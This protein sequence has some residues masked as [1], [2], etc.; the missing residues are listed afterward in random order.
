MKQNVKYAVLDAMFAMY[1][2]V[3]LRI[4]KMRAAAMWRRGVKECYKMKKEVGTP[5]VYLF[6]D[7]KHMVWAPMT[8]EKNKFFKPSIRQLRVMG[9][10]HGSEKVKN[11]EDAKLFSYYYTDSKWG[12]E[13]CDVENRLR[14]QK[15]AKWTTY[16]INKLSE[17]MKK[18]RDYRLKRERQCHRHQD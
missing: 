17:P 4:E 11:V 2:P 12:A 3:I 18:C 8:Y 9:K 15:L 5:R 14:T 16:Y 10:M 7:A 1:E 13:G 6:F